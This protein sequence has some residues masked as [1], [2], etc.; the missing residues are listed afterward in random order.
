[1][2]VFF[3]YIFLFIIC[4]IA[5]H[6]L[7]T[8]SDKSIETEIGGQ[9]KL[10]L[11]GIDYNN[12]SIH[13]EF[14]DNTW[15]DSGL[16]LRI[17][18]R[19]F[20]NDN[21]SFDVHYLFLSS[22]GDSIKS[23]NYYG[24][25]YPGT[26]ISQIFKRKFDDDNTK[27][28]DMSSEIKD[29]DDC[30]LSHR[31]DR[32]NFSLE[33]S[34]GRITIGRQ[35]VTWGNGLVFNPMDV[36]NPF[37][38]YDTERDYKKGDDMLYFE[39]SFEKGDDLQFI[40]VPR[41]D[42]EHGNLKFSHSSTGIKYHIPLNELEFDF[43]LA[44]HYEDAIAGLG[45]VVTLGDT[46]WRSDVVYTFAGG[47]MEDDFLSL[48][49]NIDYSWVWFKKNFYGL[50]EYYYSGIG[51]EDNYSKA[52]TDYDLLTRIG[53]GEIYGF[54]KHYLSSSVNIELSP[55]INFN[56]TAIINLNDPSYLIQPGIIWSAA[57]NFEIT[58][59]ANIAI[60]EKNDEYGQLLIPMSEKRMD[61]GSSLFLWATLFF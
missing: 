45:C 31:I 40:F 57:Q 17:K 26:L 16:N 61:Y 37:S 60:G 29:E 54:G 49:V 1:M 41:R 44:R 55:L 5:S 50:V 59:G 13:S 23:E 10:S 47:N 18:S 33:A 15:F 30:F 4:F 38:P 58:I 27:L 51:E 22:L 3:V 20:F 19:T 53:R 56:F 28:F 43:L 35:A 7:A 32:F 34:F 39:T 24:G 14:E 12:D 21:L 9:V 48:I 42:S 6:A 52:F 2:R 25:I 8:G 46:V 36:F 11:T